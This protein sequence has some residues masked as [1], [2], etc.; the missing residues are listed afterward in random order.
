M[1]ARRV[2]WIFLA[3]AITVGVTFI[4]LRSLECPSWDVWVT[5]QGG[6]PVPGATVRVTY[7]NYSAERESHEMDAITD[8]QGHAKF[9]V[10]TLST[11]L[12]RR[13]VAMLSSASAGVH[14][15]FGPHASVSAF[16]NGLE[17]FAIDKQKN[18]VIDWAG[19]PDHMESR[20]VVTR[21][22]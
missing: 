2:L 6:Q 13:I 20:I 15:S 11:S 18:V 14:A 17:G 21:Q 5:D 16:G 19:K 3:I 1:S 10:Q 22:Q 12:S 4:P 8:G 7:Q 9:S